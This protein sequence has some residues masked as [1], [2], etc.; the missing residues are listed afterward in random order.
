MQSRQFLKE[1]MKKLT[2][3]SVLKGRKKSEESPSR[4]TNETVAE[5]REKILA[6]GRRFKYP[7]QYARHKLVINAL[8]IVVA[9]V[10]VLALLGWWQ[11]YFVQNSSTFLYRVTRI[12]PVPV[13]SVD[14]E[15]VP[16]G[17]YL[18]KYRGSEYY[19]SKYSEEKLDSADGKKQLDHFKRVALNS[20]IADAYAQK[21]ARINNVTINDKDV[22]AVIDLQRNTA[23]GRITEETFY[24]SSRMLYDWS[25]DDYR[26]QLSRSILRSRVAF[27]IDKT[28]VERETKAATLLGENNND[29]RLVAS[30]MGGEGNAKVQ[31]G[32]SGPVDI[33]GTFGGLQ[34]SEVA[35]VPKGTVSSV[36]LTSTDGG[37]Y[38]VRVLD[39]NEK[40]INFEYLHIPLA[41]FANQL[42]RLKAD[43]KIHEYIAVPK[44]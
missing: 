28:A 16:F 27:A 10:V 18:V 39:K 30:L 22:D 43:G 23:N 14:G 29:F 1:N 40:Q 42:A 35:K 32:V 11:L 15:S 20:A 2:L 19:M 38:Y 41:E 25:P 17:D 6:G 37:Y 5:H 8:M 36:L 3:K 24:A 44:E 31:A 12:I 4:I 21:L 9:S 26:S 33:T 7:I 13:A 34:V